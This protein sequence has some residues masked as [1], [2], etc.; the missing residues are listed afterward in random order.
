MQ[1]ATN[2]KIPKRSAGATNWRTPSEFRFRYYRD[3][4]LLLFDAGTNQRQGRSP[5]ARIALASRPGTGKPLARRPA[6]QPHVP[7]APQ[8]DIVV[9]V[10][11]LVPVTEQRPHVLLVVVPRAAAQ[12]CSGRT[13]FLTTPK[14]YRVR[15]CIASAAF[16]SLHPGTVTGS[17]GQS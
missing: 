1:L 2:W 3:R 14:I 6:S 15:A 16:Q 5:D 13:P 10:P 4:A 8:P 7:H 17:S 12:H 11:R 9:S